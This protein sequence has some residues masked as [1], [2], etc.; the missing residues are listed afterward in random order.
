MIYRVILY[1]YKGPQA[2]RSYTMHAV[3]KRDPGE[4]LVRRRL[5]TGAEVDVIATQEVG[6]KEYLGQ[7]KRIYSKPERDE[8]KKGD[9]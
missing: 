5:A 7:R 8:T 3:T 2:S 6:R 1:T 9:T 4:W